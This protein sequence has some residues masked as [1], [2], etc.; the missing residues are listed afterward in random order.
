MEKNLKKKYTHTYI[1]MYIWYS[2]IILL[3]TWTLKIN[4]TSIKKKR[5]VE[6]GHMVLWKPW[7]GIWI[8]TLRETYKAL[9]RTVTWIDLVCWKN[10]PGSSV[11]DNL[12]GYKGRNWWP[13]RRWMQDFSK[14]LWWLHPG[15]RQWRHWQAVRCSMYFEGIVNKV[16]WW[17]GHG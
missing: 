9:K 3:Y 4:Y 15:W 1:H 17:N 10:H 11:E 8:F 7:W 12:Q 6:P 16:S 13:V 14:T 5:P 2:W